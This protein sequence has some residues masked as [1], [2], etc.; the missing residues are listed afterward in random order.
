MATAL[1]NA[2]LSTKVTASE[3]DRFVEICERIGTTPAN[4]M[5]MFVSAFNRRGGFPFDPANPYGF[6]EETLAAMDDALNGRNLI[7]PFDSVE[8]MMASLDDDEE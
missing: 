6:N 5:R 4:A 7:G 1:V 8:A 2:P 3:K